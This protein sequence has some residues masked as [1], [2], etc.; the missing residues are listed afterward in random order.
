MS[1]ETSM[2]VS[3]RGKAV[4]S[5]SATAFIV[6]VR[7]MSTIKRHNTTALFRVFLDKHSASN[8]QEIS[9]FNQS[10]KWRKILKFCHTLLEINANK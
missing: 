5:E 7:T 2:F 8:S 9:A 6:L 3:K 4:T 1:Q 10:P